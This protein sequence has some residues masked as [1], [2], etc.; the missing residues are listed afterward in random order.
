MKITKAQLK[1]VI[2]EELEALML[3]SEKKHP[4]VAKYVR[5]ERRLVPATA[6][7]Y[8]NASYA[9]R[10]NVISTPEGYKKWVQVEKPITAAEFDSALMAG[11]RSAYQVYDSEEEKLYWLWRKTGSPS[12]KADYDELVKNKE[13][14]K[15]SV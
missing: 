5:S 4:Y 15:N 13:E 6:K 14:N 7:D 8:D 3:E 12:I 9:G 10:R 11:D 1:Q 2:K